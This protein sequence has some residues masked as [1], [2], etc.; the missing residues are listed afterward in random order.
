M[1]DEV[2]RVLRAYWLFEHRISPTGEPAS[3]IVSDSVSPHIPTACSLREHFNIIRWY[4]FLHFEFYIR[5]SSHNCTDVSCIR[6]LRTKL[7][8]NVCMCLQMIQWTWQSSSLSSIVQSLSMKFR[9]WV[10]KQIGVFPPRLAAYR[11]PNEL[12]S[13][14]QSSRKTPR[15]LEH[16]FPELP[17]IYS[18]RGMKSVSGNLCTKVEYFPLHPPSSNIFLCAF[19]LEL[20]FGKAGCSSLF[21]LE[22]SVQMATNVWL[23]FMLK[24]VDLLDTVSKSH[25]PNPETKLNITKLQ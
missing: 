3:V 17:N 25:L 22:F 16:L 12:T 14:T 19:A 23:Y 5:S 1:G 24:V 6:P 11:R 9:D 15:Y 10:R 20:V 2:Q 4:P 7:C 18:S 8:S 13:I 21:L